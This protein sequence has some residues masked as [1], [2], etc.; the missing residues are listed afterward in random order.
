M[1]QILKISFKN[2][3][4]Y[5]GVKEFDL[6]SNKGTSIIFGN[7]NTGKTSFINGI[8]F[9]LFNYLKDNPDDPNY[10]I[11]LSINKIAYENEDYRFY[12]YM[13]FIYNGKTYKMKR[14][15]NFD[16][17]VMGKPKSDN[18][19]KMTMTLQEDG[20]YQ[21]EKYTQDIIDKI[22]P[23]DISEFM[24]FD[25]ENI[26]KYIEILNNDSATGT[27]NR[28][29][30]EAINKIIGTPFIDRIIARLD[31]LY[32]Q[33]YYQISSIVNRNSKNE[34]DKKEL[35]DK[36]QELSLKK[37]EID[38]LNRKIEKEKE[39]LT[40]LNEDLDANGR[41]IAAYK[42]L[43]KIEKEINS[44][45]ALIKSRKTDIKNFLKENIKSLQYSKII[46]EIKTMEEKFSLI[47]D[48]HQIINKFR[49]EL[50][51]YEDLLNNDT[52]QYCGSHLPLEKIV[53]FKSKVDEIK[54][55]IS[56]SSLS[57]DEMTSYE[58]SNNKIV[59]FTKILS[60]LTFF[61]DKTLRSYQEDLIMYENKRHSL[62]NDAK[63]T[64]DELSSSGSDLNTYF[65][66]AFMKK[67]QS[68]NLISKWETT[69]NENLIK[70]YE[71]LNGKI[72][73]LI[74]KMGTDFDTSDL[75]NELKTIDHVRT[76]YKNSKEQF[77]STMR[78]KVQ[79][80]SSDIFMKFIEGENQDIKQIH[81]NE[82]YRM[83]IVMKDDSIMPIPGTGYNTLLALSLI[84]G[85][86]HNSQLFG[87]I[88]FDA[89]FSVLQNSYTNNIIKTFNEIAPQLI[90]LIHNDKI[91]I[92]KTR[93]ILGNK[94]IKELEIYQEGNSFNTNVREK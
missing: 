85:L 3:I 31:S 12:A 28:R 67:T 8:R 75:E 66:D 38:D 86:N 37:K 10:K 23:K 59:K 2:F 94:L 90:L 4:P 40:R 77:I 42:Y 61:N 13:E 87:T 32:S 53:F 21:S 22:I 24:L 47:S 76:T 34:N 43:E 6:G 51:T 46:Q 35:Q 84:F 29:I 49:V 73:A 62:L 39:E 41:K 45:E 15:Y 57:S 48:R 91:D 56:Q 5:Y 7:N 89:A 14:E 27:E 58:Y 18:D 16:S 72:T 93:A 25:G 65:K 79:I 74:K 33:T 69:L 50:K 36:Q 1:I 64:R 55:K 92:S 9:L 44:T 54:F 88:F 83:K 63:K 78:Q 11:S 17:N 81:I 80:S 82:N 20:Q 68:E 60:E 30:K 70:D 26:E 52:C 71:R 19:F